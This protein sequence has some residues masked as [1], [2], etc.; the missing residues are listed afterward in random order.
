MV[1]RVSNYT[2]WGN[3][4]FSHPLHRSVWLVGY[5]TLTNFLRNLRRNFCKTFLQQN[6]EDWPQRRRS[7]SR[8][9]RHRG[10]AFSEFV[11]LACRVITKS[12]F[13][14]QFLPDIFNHDIR[15]M[16]K[17]SGHDAQD[18]SRYGK[19]R[20]NALQKKWLSENLIFVYATARAIFLGYRC[21]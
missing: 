14:S 20:Q 17:R 1:G 5:L 9:F 21:L 18:F 8:K 15:N 2:P 12:K 11:I 19:L 6:E 7:N 13:L 3:A 10:P 4:P 16:C